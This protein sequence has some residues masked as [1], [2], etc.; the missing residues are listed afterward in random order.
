MKWYLWLY[1]FAVGSAILIVALVPRPSP[2]AP[3]LRREA[4]VSAWATSVG[5]VAPV[6]G[7][8]DSHTLGDDDRCVLAIGTPDGSTGTRP[9]CPLWTGQRSDVL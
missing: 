1:V 8:D 5:I 6:V 2:V 4:A 7:C 3:R 9:S